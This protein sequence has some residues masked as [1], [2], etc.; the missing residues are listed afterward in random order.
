MAHDVLLFFSF[1]PLLTLQANELAHKAVLTDLVPLAAMTDSPENV[2][3][4]FEEK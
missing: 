4:S 2:K 3:K 1:F